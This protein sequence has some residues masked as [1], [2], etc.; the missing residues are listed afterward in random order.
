MYYR[1]TIVAGKTIMRSYRAATR[2]KTAGEKRAKRSNP[3]P[4]AVAKTNYRNSVKVLTAKLNHNFSGGDLHVVLTYAG[5]APDKDQAKKD[6]DNFI[7]DMRR[8]H[9]KSG[10][11]FK[12]VAVTE[13]KHKRIHHHV[14]LNCRDLPKI[15]NRWKHGYVKVAVL[16]RSGNYHKLAAYLLK[17]T[18]KTFRA[19]DSPTKKRYRCAMCVT[20]PEVKREKVSGRSVGKDIKPPKGYYLD[21][22]SVRKYEHAILGVECLEYICISATDD[23]RLKRWTKG[24]KVRPERWYRED[25]QLQ[26]EQLSF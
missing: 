8:D 4:D 22:D 13:Y 1:E 11:D 6:L 20:M 17:E 10:K 3:T 5:D 14:V 12:W 21:E 26:I 7:G 9:R 15:E 18:E 16:D 25:K 19:P 24:K 23:P 2:V